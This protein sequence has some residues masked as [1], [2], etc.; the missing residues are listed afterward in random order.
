[1]TES[2]KF[3]KKTSRKSLFK[4]LCFNNSG[5]RK[6]KDLL[7]HSVKEI[8]VTIQ[9]DKHKTQTLS[10]Y[11]MA[12]LYR[13]FQNLSPGIGGKVLTDYLI[14]CSDSYIFHEQ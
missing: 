2:G 13:R 10:V 9:S 11:S 7:K 4:I 5:T 12:K 6:I 14:N 3:K 8:Y 1:M